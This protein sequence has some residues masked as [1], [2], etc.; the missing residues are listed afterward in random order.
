MGDDSKR[1]SQETQEQWRKYLE[2]RFE[3]D[4]DLVY[5]RQEYG[6]SGPTGP[7]G[8]LLNSEDYKSTGPTGPTGPTGSVGDSKHYK[9]ESDY[10]MDP[11]ARPSFRPR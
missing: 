7:I 2:E 10:R 11:Q 3:L 6:Y 5:Q 8:L 1:F 4:Q 9:S